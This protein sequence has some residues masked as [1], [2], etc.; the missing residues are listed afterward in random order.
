MSEAWVMPPADSIPTLEIQ[1]ALKRKGLT[2]SSTV[3]STYSSVLRYNLVASGR[4][5][6]VLPKSM[7]G[8]MGK[9]HALKALPVHLP[10]KQR[11]IAIIVLKKRML[12]PI[13]KLFIETV[14]SVAKP[15]TKTASSPGAA[16]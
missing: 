6:T 1:D 5:I 14:R 16:G 2:L 9:S 13:A 3:V 7:L 11:T 4:F 10:T 8:V 15:R 12:S